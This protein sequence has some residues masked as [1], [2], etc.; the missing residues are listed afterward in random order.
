MEE[1]EKGPYEYPRGSRRLPP[2]ASS[3]CVLGVSSSP[4]FCLPPVGGNNLF[5]LGKFSGPWVGWMVGWWEG[6][7]SSKLACPP[8]LGLRVGWLVVQGGGKSNFHLPPPLVGWL[9]GRGG[10]AR[11]PTH[12]KQITAI[13]CARL[14]IESSLL[15]LSRRSR[16]SPGSRGSAIWTVACDPP[17]SRRGPG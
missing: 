14:R 1:G 11:K 17:S 3:R 8:F 9:V 16:Q 7:G 10:G 5:N 2:S 15:E 6:G 12:E 13:I 4:F